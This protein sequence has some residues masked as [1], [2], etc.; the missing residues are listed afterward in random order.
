LT[1][2]NFQRSGYFPSGIQLDLIPFGE[3]APKHFLYLERPEGMERRAAEGFVLGAPPRE[4]RVRPACSPSHPGISQREELRGAGRPRSVQATR[5]GRGLGG[6]VSR[7]LGGATEGVESRTS[8]RPSP[9][10]C[11][12]VE[13]RA[14][15]FDVFGTQRGT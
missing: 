9:I 2:P 8:P 12:K 15:T 3:R 4:A 7:R 14:L 5:R 13:V 1:R 10:G 11:L 6:V